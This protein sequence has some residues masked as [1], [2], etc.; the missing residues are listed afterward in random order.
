VQP[1]ESG[2][3]ARHGRPRH[4]HLPY[5]NLT[6]RASQALR[7]LG[8]GLERVLHALQRLVALVGVPLLLLLAVLIA[9]AVA[10]VWGGR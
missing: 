8:R 2:R 3:A 10:A 9:A 1:R 4:H 5:P 7:R 6:S